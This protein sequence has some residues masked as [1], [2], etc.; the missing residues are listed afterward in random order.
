MRRASYADLCRRLTFFERQWSL[1]LVYVYTR[2][3]ILYQQQPPPTNSIHIYIYIDKVARRWYRVL[4]QELSIIRTAST[5]CF[6]A[7]SRS[8]NRVRYYD[9][10]SLIDGIT[11]T[12]CTRIDIIFFPSFLSIDSSS[13]SIILI[14]VHKVTML[15]YEN[16]NRANAYCY[17]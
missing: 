4:H 8:R 12:L 15:R 13:D 9:T 14:K 10:T 7:S 2:D 1:Y 16:S 6:Q 3:L 17:Y 5:S 11:S